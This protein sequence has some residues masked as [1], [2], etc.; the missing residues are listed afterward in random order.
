VIDEAVAELQVAVTELRDLARGI[1]P[2]VLTDGGLPR[3][4]ESL[5]LRM[6]LPVELDVPDGRDAPH[7]EAAAY[8]VA[9]EA[10]ANVVKHAQASHAS[11]VVRRDDGILR[12]AVADD[13]VGGVDP[14]PGS[15]LSGLA[16]R[17][18]ALGGTLSAES[19]P[20]GGTRLVATLPR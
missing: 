17:V 13:G 1:H 18:E 11:I 15:G 3:A 19:P 8:F 16:A 2:A 7:V 14:Q 5:A 20:A 10:L 12:I 9:C 4:L 6:P